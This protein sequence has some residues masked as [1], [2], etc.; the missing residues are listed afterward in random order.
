MMTV[1]I[2]QT[3]KA[4]E[5]IQYE[6][7]LNN[8]TIP[9]GNVEEILKSFNNNMSVHLTKIKTEQN[10]ETTLAD[11]CAAMSKAAREN[12]QLK[13]PPRKT[14]SCHPELQP[15]IDARLQATKN[16]DYEGVESIIED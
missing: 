11:L 9:D 14:K 8:I 16:Y 5:D 10:R 1:E 3:L 4:K 13:E 15:I 6:R 7:S 12:L 2:K